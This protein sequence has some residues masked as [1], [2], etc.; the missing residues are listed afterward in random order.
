MTPGPT[1]ARKSSKRRRQK[2]VR[3][4]KFDGG[5]RHGSIQPGMSFHRVTNGEVTGA[6]FSFSGFPRTAMVETFAHLKA[7]AIFFNSA[8][9]AEC[10]TQ[11]RPLRWP[12]SAGRDRQRPPGYANCIYRKARTLLYP[13]R[14]E[15][16]KA[17]VP[18]S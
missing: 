13:G 2:R 11:R 3:L 14:P 7:S 17:A 10:V 15:E 1:T 18:F 16:P 8:S 12:R 9:G 6:S 5:E 4:P